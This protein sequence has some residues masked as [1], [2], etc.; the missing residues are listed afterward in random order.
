MWADEGT[1]SNKEREEIPKIS[2]PQIPDKLLYLT[3]HSC[4]RSNVLFIFTSISVS[5]LFI[6]Y[7]LF[8]ISS[9]IP[10]VVSSPKT[11][12]PFPSYPTSMKVFPHTLPTP[13]S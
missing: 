6:I 2:L 13:V 10:F 11:P 5:F 12:N 8:C 9:I 3:S 1:Q 7:F 4:C